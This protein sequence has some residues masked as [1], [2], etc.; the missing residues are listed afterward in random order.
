MTATIS[1]AVAWVA[2]KVTRPPAALLSV[3]VMPWTAIAVT[4]T[5]TSLEGITKL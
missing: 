3:A 2:L 1:P 5:A 4:V